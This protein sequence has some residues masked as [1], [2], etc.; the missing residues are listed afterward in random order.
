MALRG[1]WKWE[2]HVGGFL[3][4]LP[5]SSRVSPRNTW[6][7]VVGRVCHGPGVPERCTRLCTC[8]PALCVVTGIDGNAL[9]VS[10]ESWC[11]QASFL[12]AEA[13]LASPPP[14]L[15]SRAGVTGKSLTSLILKK[16]FLSCGGKSRYDFYIQK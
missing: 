14:S 9:E 10:G 2:F 13:A 1:L 6:L 8:V 3:Q 11:L 16:K 7:H 15:G 4:A 12:G 5:A